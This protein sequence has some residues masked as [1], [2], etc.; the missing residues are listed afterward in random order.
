MR[1]L[2][3]YFEKTTYS[4]IHMVI[5]YVI[6]MYSL[7]INYL[8]TFG[9]GTLVGITKHIYR[10]RREQVMSEVLCDERKTS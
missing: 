5:N 8:Y 4:C 9:H 7:I 10:S 2:A 1:G 6:S 3:V